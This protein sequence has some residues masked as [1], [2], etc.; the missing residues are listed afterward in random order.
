MTAA[1]GGTTP[2]LP[3]F[4]SYAVY[5]PQRRISVV[6]FVNSDITASGQQAKPA[7]LLAEDIIAV[8]PRRN[9]SRTLNRF[10]LLSCP[11]LRQAER[12]DRLEELK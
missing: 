12:C 7:D 8:L 1:G 2:P 6:V 11:L 4:T 9:C 10:G 5:H 3:G